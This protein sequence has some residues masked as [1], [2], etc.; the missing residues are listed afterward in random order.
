MILLLLQHIYRAVY[1][2]QTKLIYSLS[3]IAFTF[4]SRGS[5]NIGSIIQTSSDRGAQAKQGERIL[6]GHAN[7]E[8]EYLRML[9]LYEILSTYK[10][11][12]Q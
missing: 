8:P 4:I 12:W 9:F 3:R 6:N 2:P 1:P 11:S 7:E 5:L 10:L